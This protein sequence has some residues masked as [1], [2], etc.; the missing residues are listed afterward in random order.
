[1]HSKY[2]EIGLIII[3]WAYSIEKVG[4]SVSVF[5]LTNDFKVF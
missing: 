1:M 5:I 4:K 2:K 3:D